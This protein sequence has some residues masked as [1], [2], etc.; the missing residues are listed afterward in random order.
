MQLQV[1]GQ[2]VDVTP[3]LRSHV[4]SKLNGI[5]KLFDNVTSLNVVLSIEKL[6]HRVDATLAAAGRVLHANASEGDMYASID[7]VFDKLESQLRKH[8]EKV[9][10]HHQ[11]K[12]R[13][14]RYA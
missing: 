11:A 2:Q 6:M 13:K 10:D 9:T 1:S 8:K 14:E 5:D 3:A 12:A 7:V 4:E